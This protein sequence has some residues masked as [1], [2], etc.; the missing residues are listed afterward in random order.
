MK[1]KLFYIFLINMFFASVGNNAYSQAFPTGGTPPTPPGGGPPP[2]QPGG[3]G[4]TGGP[5]DNGAVLFL[6][7]ISAYGY[8]KVKANRI[9][10]KSDT[11]I[12]I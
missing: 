2:Q 7:A 9:A 10:R 1:N 8:T 5:I 6:V 3:G 4:G 12:T 11:E